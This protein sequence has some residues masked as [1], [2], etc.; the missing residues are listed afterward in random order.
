[1]NY[2]CIAVVYAILAVRVNAAAAY[3]Y[4]IDTYSDAILIVVMDRGV[5]N[6]KR[7]A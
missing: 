6:R 4:G 3:V 7:G 5:G 1:V 2:R